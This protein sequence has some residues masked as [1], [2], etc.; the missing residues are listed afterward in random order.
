[1]LLCVLHLSFDRSMVQRRCSAV[2]LRLATVVRGRLRAGGRRRLACRFALVSQ[3]A[4]LTFASA[5]LARPGE[6]G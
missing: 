6:D 5:L 4:S 2:G 3:R 1:V